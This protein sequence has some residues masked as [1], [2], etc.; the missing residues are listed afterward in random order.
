MRSLLPPNIAGSR[1][2]AARWPPPH[3]TDVGPRAVCRS[4][5]A[6]QPFDVAQRQ[7]DIG[8]AAVIA[9]AAVRRRLHLAQQRVHLGRIEAAARSHARMARQGAADMLDPLLQGER[10]TPFLELVG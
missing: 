9:L 5:A 1:S 8:R 10:V 7:A 3:P 6:E 4:A 2:E